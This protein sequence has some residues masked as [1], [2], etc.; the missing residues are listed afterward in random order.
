MEGMAYLWRRL[1]LSAKIVMPYLLLTLLV[2]VGGTFVA[3]RLAAQSANDR[4]TTG[5]VEALRT[6]NTELLEREGERVAALGTLLDRDGVAEAVARRDAARLVALLD[7]L[8]PGADWA[9]VV[10]PSGQTLAARRASPGASARTGDAGDDSSRSVAGSPPRSLAGSGEGLAVGRAGPVD[11]ALQ[12]VRDFSGERQGGFGELNGEAAFVAA[13]PVRLGDRVVGAL[14]VGSDLTTVVQELK[15][16][17][18]ADAALFAA[19]GRPLVNTLAPGS[20]GRPGCGSATGSTSR[21]S[22]RCGCAA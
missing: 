19:D 17:T 4:L 18:V 21:W 1:P 5:L 8:P 20:C 7:P 3:T 16:T 12:G 9:G 10:D 6:A 14:A 13:A 15:R 11:L 22:R 2:G